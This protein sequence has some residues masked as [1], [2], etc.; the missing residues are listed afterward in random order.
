MDTKV[1]V[2]GV[3]LSSESFAVVG[4]RGDGAI[5][6]VPSTV[7]VWVQPPVLNT[8]HWLAKSFC[9][10]RRVACVCLRTTRYG[11]CAEAGCD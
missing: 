10:R 7:H 1:S 8:V 9:K 4:A 11:P 2:V 3:D 6:I 5:A